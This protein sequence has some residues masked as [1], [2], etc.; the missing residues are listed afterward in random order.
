MLAVGVL[1]ASSLTPPLADQF[2]GMEVV[3]LPDGD[4]GGETFIRKAIQIF[5]SRNVF[6][7]VDRLPSGKDVADLLLIN[8]PRRRPQ[9]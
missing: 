2:E 8:H 6:L 9:S 3:L 1:G 4:D 7:R 5:A